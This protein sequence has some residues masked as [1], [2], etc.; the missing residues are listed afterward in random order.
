[1]INDKTKI[2]LIFISVVL[3]V[4]SISVFFTLPNLDEKEVLKAAMPKIQDA[5]IALVSLEDLYSNVQSPEKD[6]GTHF[7]VVKLN[8][9]LFSEKDRTIIEKFATPIK[10]K[11][12]EISRNQKYEDLRTIAGKLY[13]KELIVSN[14]NEMLKNAFIRDAQFVS[15]YVN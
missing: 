12:I 2:T 8:L 14:I 1:M 3:L 15:F 6:E 4:L 11:V 7:V 5:S 9:V 10:D 13:Y